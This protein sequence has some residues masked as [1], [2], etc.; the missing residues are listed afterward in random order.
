MYRLICS[1]C[2][3]VKGEVVMPTCLV[4]E[5]VITMFGSCPSGAEAEG[6]AR[7]V[8]VGVLYS[9]EVKFS[10]THD[11]L[12]P[13]WCSKSLS[14]VGRLVACPSSRRFT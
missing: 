4:P 1:V 13:R 3:D 12:T 7:V 14:P 10:I 9:S 8:E 11:Q 6:R 5:D 2:G